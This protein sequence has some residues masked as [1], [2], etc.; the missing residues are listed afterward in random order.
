MAAEVALITLVALAALTFRVRLPKGSPVAAAATAR[1]D[2]LPRA[3]WLA[4]LL[5]GVTGSIEVCLSLWAA[6]MLRSHAGM[7]P[8][9]ASAA[10]ASIVGGMFLGRLLGGRVALRVAPVPLLLGA[11]AVSFLGFAVFWASPIGWIAVTGLGVVGLGNAMHYPLGISMALAAAAGQAD[12]AAA[13]SS[14]SVAVEFGMAPVGLGWLADSLGPHLA[15][16]LLPLFIAAAA[17]LAVRLGRALRLRAASLP[18][19]DV[20]VNGPAAQ[21][22]RRKRR[23]PP[24]RSFWMHVPCLHGRGRAET[25]R[26]KGPSASFSRTRCTAGQNIRKM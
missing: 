8:G 11:L 5:M 25:G 21:R 3:Y 19:L 20:R 2:R 4:W 13:Y 18:P 17:L 16:L 6:D 1:P 15:F 9:G 12:R 23:P 7:S 22:S 10:L 24:H 14:Y 26:R